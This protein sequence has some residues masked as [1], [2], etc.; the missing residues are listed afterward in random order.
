V[1]I[2]IVASKFPPIVGG[3]E[4]IVYNQAK[5]LGLRGHT[6]SVITSSLPK[7]YKPIKEE[8]LFKIHYISGF[9]D[10]CLGKGS[11]RETCKYL[12]K[13][14]KELEPDIVHVHNIIPM[15]LLSQF[16]KN[17]PSKIVFTYHNTPNP[18][19][20][21][22]GYF[23]NFELDEAFAQKVMSSNSFDLLIA[24]SKF[25]YDWAIRLGSNK[26]KVKLLYFWI[27]GSMFNSSLL[28]RRNEFRTKYRISRNKF[29]ITL[30]SRAI[31]R[32]G[33]LEAVQSLS[34]LKKLGFTPTLFLPAFYRPFDQK[35]ANRVKSEVNRLGIQDQIIIPKVHIPY[36]KM[37]G[38]YAMSNL[39]IMPSYNEGLGVALLEA[40][41][42]GVPTIGARVHGIK[43]VISDRQNGLLVRSKSPDELA[44]AIFKLSNDNDLMEKIARNGIRFIKTKFSSKKIVTRL[45]N[46]YNTLKSKHDRK[47]HWLYS[48]RRT[49]SEVA[50]T[51]SGAS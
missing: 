49:G 8:G 1:R 35:Y 46:H 20:R 10:F 45:E 40:M 21:I 23:D 41:S 47:D 44:K 12:H 34:I 38:V 31:E 13:T 51:N 37:P 29:V 28:K 2:V 26:R 32:K 50:A 27:D 5:E 39:V 9:E 48:S 7:K 30:P 16:A 14:L 24:G 6:V 22:L 25:Y 15:F 42:M 3:G 4:T 19:K 17:L 33:A 36:E 11:F 43:E 18:P